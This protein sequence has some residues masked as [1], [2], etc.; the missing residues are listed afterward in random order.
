MIR[1]REPWRGL[2]AGEEGSDV[3][4][5]EIH[6][7]QVLILPLFLGMSGEQVSYETQASKCRLAPIPGS[8][9]G[10]DPDSWYLTSSHPAVPHLVLWRSG[11]FPRCTTPETIDRSRFPGTGILYSQFLG[12]IFSSCISAI[13]LIHGGPCKCY[14]MRN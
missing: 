3:G 11:Y 5:G 4:N 7:R 8:A 12:L 14:H 13:G 6:I 9:G 2:G 1:Y 10:Q